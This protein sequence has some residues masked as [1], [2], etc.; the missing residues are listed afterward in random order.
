[1]P[2]SFERSGEGA[3]NKENTF[4]GLD[5]NGLSAG[6]KRTLRDYM[7]PHEGAN[8]YREHAQYMIDFFEHPEEFEATDF[9]KCTAF[10]DFVLRAFD[11]KNVWPGQV[12]PEEIDWERLRNVE[13]DVIPSTTG[14]ANVLKAEARKDANSE[15]Q[16][17]HSNGVAFSLEDWVQRKPKEEEEK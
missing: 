13:V 3:K 5:V 11:S 17:M 9:A 10:S 8:Y 6:Q 2:E 12:K 7:K 14:V 1:M 16:E 15:W 4:A